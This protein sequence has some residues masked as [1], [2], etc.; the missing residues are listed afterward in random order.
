[1]EKVAETEYVRVPKTM[2]D[3]LEERAKRASAYEE[4]L[5]D[6]AAATHGF[7][8]T[9]VVTHPPSGTVSGTILE[10]IQNLAKLVRP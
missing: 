3:Q 8:V 6:F 1:V 2:F 5:K 7:M 4:A 9:A 10:S